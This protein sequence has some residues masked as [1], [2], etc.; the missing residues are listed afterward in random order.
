[1][2]LKTLAAMAGMFTGGAPS[3]GA[4]NLMEQAQ[5]DWRLLLHTLQRIAAAC[6]AIERNT[7]HDGT[8]NGNLAGFPHDGAARPGNA[9]G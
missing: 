2:D 7:R 9:S 5:G 8:H 6:E 1:M 4:A 3:P